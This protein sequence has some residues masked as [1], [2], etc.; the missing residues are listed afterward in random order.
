MEGIVG[1]ALELLDSV[2][3]YFAAKLRLERYRLETQTRRLIFRSAVVL[4]SA[5]VM[6]LGLVFLSFGIADLVGRALGSTSA[7]RMIVGGFY[8]LAGAI[9]LFVAGRRGSKPFR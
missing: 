2:F 3:E 4:G 6:L 7:G 1:N 8:F 9:A 5:A